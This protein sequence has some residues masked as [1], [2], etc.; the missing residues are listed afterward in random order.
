VIFIDTGAF[1]ARYVRRDQ[2][3][4]RARA[5]WQALSREPW[6]CYTSNF[7]LD[8]TFTLLARRASY[9]FAAQRARALM[10]SKTLEILRPQH[11][12]ELEAVNLFEKFADQA[13]SFTDCTSF[14]LMRRHRIPRVFT[15][16]HH[17][18]LAGFH[19]WPA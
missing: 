15:F 8:E 12:D 14:A 19:L 4:A 10:A 7:V 17:F 9:A 3:H 18:G 1:V 16:D 11:E 13:V 5:A 2:Y 6:R